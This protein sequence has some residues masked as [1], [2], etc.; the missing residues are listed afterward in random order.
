MCTLNP[1][2]RCQRPDGGFTLLEMLVVIGVLSVLMGMSIGYLQRTDPTA[3]GNA[4]LAGELRA[5][6]LTARAEGAPTEVWLRPGKDAEASTVQAR[7]LVPAVAFR[8]EPNAG[9][10]DE[11][12]VA[13]LSGEVVP[14]GRFG[15]ARRSRP[16]DKQALLR[17]P[18]PPSVLDLSDGFVVRCDVFLE[19]RARAAL[20]RMQPAFDLQL[21]DDLRLVAR[22]RLRGPGGEGTVLASVK[23]TLA[24][25]LRQWC[26]V[27]LG[28]DG[29][30]VW[31]SLDGR[32][33]AREV[34]A[35]SPLQELASVFEMSPPEAPLAGV[36]DE[37]R[38]FVYAFSPAQLMPIELQFRAAYRFGF[39][40]R[41]E[42][43]ER[44]TVQYVATQ[45]G[46]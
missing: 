33:L 11:T 30:T 26:T 6:Q 2:Q 21:E 27:D 15:H 32:E 14:N 13:E 37:V 23:S 44:P 40:A 12:L 20:L 42:A 39:D 3:I 8:F 24:L 9:A 16:G 36:I 10:L 43:T 19:Q 17:W 35:G 18:T 28:C 1:L 4:V 31:L 46:S 41:G 38:W 7:L 25:P 5:A 29:S 45:G 34:A 22:F